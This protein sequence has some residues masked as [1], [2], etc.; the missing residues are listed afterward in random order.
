[1]VLYPYIFTS[2]TMSEYRSF[3]AEIL[4]QTRKEPV[5]DMP[6]II[7]DLESFEDASWIPEE[8]RHEKNQNK[9]RFLLTEYLRA[10]NR[11]HTRKMKKEEARGTDHRLFSPELFEK[12]QSETIDHASEASYELATAKWELKCAEEERGRSRL[13]GL[14]NAEAIGS[15][16]KLERAKQREDDT[17]GVMVTVRFDADNFKIIND[18]HG[19][20]TGDHILRDIAQALEQTSRPSDYPLHFSGDE[21]GLLL[22]DVHPSKGA[23]IEETIE[24]IIRRQIEAVEH[25]IRPDGE[26]QTLSAGYKIIRKEDHG[27]FDT[28][29]AEADTATHTAKKIKHLKGKYKGSTRIVNFDT[30]NQTTSHLSRGEIKT[31]GLERSMQRGMEDIRHQLAEQLRKG[32]ITGDDVANFELLYDSLLREAKELMNK[33]RE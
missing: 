10:A 8:I 15:I 3:R 11:T 5:G 21:F 31:A 32:N 4:P 22:T 23:T 6:F 26:T 7:P 27:Y 1:M 17:T 29:D 19:H 30:R 33:G 16:F 12:I 25:I 24:S 14:L 18:E 2:R 9:K 13:T 28:F 20:A